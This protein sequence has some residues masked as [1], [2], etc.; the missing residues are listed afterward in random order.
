[1]NRKQCVDYFLSTPRRSRYQ[2]VGRQWF[3]YEDGFWMVDEANTRIDRAILACTRELGWVKG[4]MEYMINNIRRDLRYLLHTDRLSANFE[5]QFTPVDQ[6]S[7]LQAP[8]AS[9]SP[10]QPS[11]PGLPVADPGLEQADQG[12]TASP[13]GHTP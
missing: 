13:T 1:M 7:E 8:A 12:D 6:P 3:A 4:G 9:R 5:A 10:V 2:H 11:S